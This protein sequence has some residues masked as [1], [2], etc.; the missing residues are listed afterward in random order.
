MTVTLIFSATKMEEV[1][2]REAQGAR[3]HLRLSTA[4]DGCPR[5][6]SRAP[7]VERDGHFCN[8]LPRSASAFDRVHRSA[9]SLAGGGLSGRVV[10]TCTSVTDVVGGAVW[11]PRNWTNQ[12]RPSVERSADSFCPAAGS[13]EDNGQHGNRINEPSDVDRGNHGQTKM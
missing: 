5:S 6:R 2:A 11:D 3:R 12:I 9:S 8:D 4:V 10:E 13:K 1:T 7:P